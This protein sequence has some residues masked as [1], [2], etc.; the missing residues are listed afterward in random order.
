MRQMKT[1][2][3]GVC[4]TSGLS[5]FVITGRRN[6]FR[7]ISATTGHELQYRAEYTLGDLDVYEEGWGV[8]NSGT[9]TLTRG[10]IEA[11]SN[12]NAKVPLSGAQ[13]TVWIVANAGMH[14]DMEQMVDGATKKYLTVAERAKLAG[15]HAA[16]AEFLAAASTKEQYL[17]LKVNGSWLHLVSING[18]VFV[19]YSGQSNCIA[20]NCSVSPAY[21][22]NSKLK[23]WQPVAPNQG[24]QSGAHGWVTADTAYAS[25]YVNG[26]SGV[27]SGLIGGG[28]TNAGV[29]MCDY[30]QKQSGLEFYLVL[31]AWS[32]QSIIKWGVGQAVRA[33]LDTQIAAALATTE[34]TGFTKA[35][36]V[37][38]D[39]GDGDM[40]RT[41]DAYVTDAMAF[42][43]YAETQW[44]D[45]G[46][47][48]WLIM[49][50]SRE[51]DMLSAQALLPSVFFPW[52]GQQEFAAQCG[53]LTKFIG[54]KDYDVAAGK[55][56][57]Y[58]GILE[59]VHFNGIQ[60]RYRGRD[61][62][63]AVL[64]GPDTASKGL[65]FPQEFQRVRRPTFTGRS[66]TADGTGN[67]V[68]IADSF[69]P[70]FA[71]M[72]DYL[73]DRQNE[74]YPY[75]LVY[76]NYPTAPEE[77]KGYGIWNPTTGQFARE[78]VTFSTAGG[79]T[80]ISFTA[81][82]HHL[83]ILDDLAV[84]NNGSLPFG[85]KMDL[86]GDG[87]CIIG[88]SITALEAQAV[89]AKVFSRSNV[90]RL[91]ASVGLGVAG[92][93]GYKNK[94]MQEE[95]SAEPSYTGSTGSKFIH[96]LYAYVGNAFGVV[97]FRDMYDWYSGRLS[98]VVGAG[99]KA[100]DT[101]KGLYNIYIWYD[102]VGPAQEA[103]SVRLTSATAGEYFLQLLNKVA[104]VTGHNVRRGIAVD[105]ATGK[106]VLTNQVADSF[107]RQFTGPITGPA[108]T[109]IFSVTLGTNA[110]EAY[111]GEVTIRGN[112][113]SGHPN[114]KACK[115]VYGYVAKPTSNGTVLQWTL[116]SSTI[117]AP[118]GNP[119]FATTAIA[120]NVTTITVAAASAS[121]VWRWSVESDQTI[122][123][124]SN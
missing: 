6:R 1:S 89:Q 84:N 69:V 4:T 64:S 111:E 96:K 49:Q 68:V 116:L 8:W 12:S 3:A 85:M 37:M 10:T 108:T 76:A 45:V 35:N 102:E 65:D 53:G 101:L 56:T 50:K 78:K 117:A 94:L 20:A 22:P 18:K 55:G 38:F 28:N 109:T 59:Y 47:T 39:Q 26:V 98:L 104:L 77:E 72:D 25:G 100:S 73:Q 46:N 118:A 29:E 31:A 9:S 75:R 99:I 62:A 2:M 15:I 61:C 11:S 41:V 16:A 83:Y 123:T 14:T 42:K 81:A 106:L 95:T 122:M 80:K 34:L 57:T 32:A 119:V 17:K 67:I 70:G 87:D 58:P 21:V 66:T 93:L 113:T 121:D 33:M 88:D 60:Q 107:A 92:V 43:A 54:S 36:I 30:L 90:W 112:T 24:G 79:T 124:A 110:A 52:Y 105:H 7:A 74:T 23:V 114:G 48:M 91:V 13:V 82:E 19:V 103:L 71:A 63:V 51:Y 115:V 40:S 86:R 5:D 97:P 44:A 120:A 27:W